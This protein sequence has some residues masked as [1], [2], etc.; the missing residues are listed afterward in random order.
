M[1]RIISLSV[2]GLVDSLL[3]KGDIDMRIYNRETMQI[4][5]K[6]HAAYQAKQGKEYLSE[7][8]LKGSFER[9][10]AIVELE[11]RAD[12][13]ILGGAYPIIDEIKSTVSD[14]DAFYKEQYEWHLGQAACYALLY[15]MKEGG[16]KVGVKLT[17]ISQKTGEKKVHSKV[18]SL[19]ELQTKVLD[20]IDLFLERQ[21]DVYRHFAARNESSEHLLFPFEHFRKGQHEMA[22]YVYSVAK[23]GGYFYIEAPTGIGKT[24]SSLYPSI[25]AFAHSRLDKIFFLSAKNSGKANAEKALE[26]LRTKGAKIRSSTLSAKEAI[27]LSKGSECQPDDC[28][29]AK[30]YYDLFPEVREEALSA[31]SH[32]GKE[33]ITALAKKHR[34]CPFELQ[35]DLSLDSDVIVA[36]YNY[37][38]DPFAKLERYFGPE[39]DPSSYFL[40]VDEAHNLIERGRKCYSERL[41]SGEIRKAKAAL[42]GYP[43][44]SPILRLTKILKEMAEIEIPEEGE[45][46]LPE[47]PA[48][49]AKAL[50]S[51][52]EAKKR[53][54]SDEK[55][56]KLPEE[57]NELSRKIY[58]LTSFLEEGR[59]LLYYA[60]KKGKGKRLIAA[61]C[62]DPSPMLMEDFS[63]V[64]G[65]VFLSATLSP[66]DYF[67]ESTL[68]KKDFPYLLLPSPF[69]PKHFRLFLA[70]TVDIRYKR[71]EETLEEVA[72]YLKA[73]VTAK[74]GNYFIYLPSFQYLTM[75]SSFLS[76]S[77]QT[78]VHIQQE[79]MNEEEKKAF[80]DNFLVNPKES[81]VGV[82]VIG[83]SFAEGIDLPYDRLI[84][85]AVVGIGLP[86]VNF[87]TEQL[88]KYFDAKLSMG[89][90]YAYRNPGINKVMQAVGRLIRTEEDVG[91]A[92][93]IDNRYTQWQY[94]DIFSRV[95]PEYEVVTDASEIAPKIKA[96][97]KANRK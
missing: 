30:H 32:L 61:F 47:F 88:R 84:G 73:F 87:E 20:L 41:S 70:P 11:G 57:I 9:E 60:T 96:F 35:L 36:D 78:K 94:R 64:K 77:P 58:R 92:L 54:A 18:F 25:K 16:E 65:A 24:M 51:F 97:Y 69:S 22:K 26:L 14:L 53:C 93:L 1:K 43:S 39:A 42:K 81:H 44:K 72:S 7:V 48:S 19:A 10:R 74:K 82:M 21:E 28:P 89:F 37:F 46:I 76:F 23:G 80:L 50:S 5:S 59:P 66:I 86:Q 29:F 15:L 90:A 4:G 8:E 12:G 85:V 34:V 17:Y 13:I 79:G 71:R 95:W 55:L 67:M 45:A 56:P 91:A 49:L 68:G 63:R 83:G 6:I 52:L 38:L 27:C 62:L 75:I 40:I 2:H 33:E 31:Y 3:R